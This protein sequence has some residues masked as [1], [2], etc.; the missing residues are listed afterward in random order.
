MQVNLPIPLRSHAWVAHLED[1]D[2]APDAGHQPM[3]HGPSRRAALVELAKDIEF[4]A[5]EDK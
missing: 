5:E 2:G 3:G 1:Y 4:W